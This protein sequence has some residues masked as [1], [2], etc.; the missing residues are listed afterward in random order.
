[1][2]RCGRDSPLPGSIGTGPCRGDAAS[3]PR[4]AGRAEPLKEPVA[5][6]S[7]EPRSALYRDGGTRQANRA[8]RSLVQVDV[9]I[10]ID[11][12]DGVWERRRQ[13]TGVVVDTGR[14]WVVTSRA[15]VPHAAADVRVTFAGSLEIA[16]SVEYIHPL[17]NLAVVSYDPVAVGSTAL[18]S[19]EFNPLPVA[20]RATVCISPVSVPRTPCCIGRFRSNRSKPWTLKR[21]KSNRGCSGISI[22]TSFR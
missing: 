14:G 7:V 11:G 6:R 10:P 21:T 9:V 1:M 18:R 8:A 20:H 2:N 13:G 17:H 22:S 15:V 3:M 12:V 19:A 16:G 5:A 4:A